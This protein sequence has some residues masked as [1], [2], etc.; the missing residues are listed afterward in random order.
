MQCSKLKQNYLSL[1]KQLLLQYQ[2]S[3]I[4]CQLLNHFLVWIENK[5]FELQEYLD[6]SGNAGFRSFL[7]NCNTNNVSKLHLQYNG[8][9]LSFALVFFFVVVGRTARVSGFKP[10]EGMA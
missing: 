3:I 7:L 4:Y 8:N 10:S 1:L 2:T 9:S 6:T 5:S